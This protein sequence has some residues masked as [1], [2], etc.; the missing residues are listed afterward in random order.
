MSEAPHTLS[1]IHIMKHSMNAFHNCHR[2]FAALAMESS[3]HFSRDEGKKPCYKV[4]EQFQKGCSL[5]R[6]KDENT[7][8]TLVSESGATAG[9]CLARHEGCTSNILQNQNRSL[10]SHLSLSED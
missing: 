5:L 1:I 4:K 6:L 10:F 2:N 7:D 8:K 3:N 9:K